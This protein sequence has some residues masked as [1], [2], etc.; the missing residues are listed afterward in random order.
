MKSIHQW[1]HALPALAALLLGIQAASAS[2]LHSQPTAYQ[3]RFAQLDAY[4]DGRLRDLS[5]P[6]AALVVVEGTD[7]VHEHAYGQ[8]SCA[9]DVPTPQTPF[10]IGS[11]TKSITA[12]AVMQLVEAG[13]IGLDDPVHDYLTWFRT[14]DPKASALITVRQLLNHTSGLSQQTGIRPLANFDDRRDAAERQARELASFQITRPPG[15]AF[16]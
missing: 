14:A 12:L 9:G 5:M 10:V 4:I 6:G 2:G 11:L 15:S 1:D 13:A 8:A 3:A 16:E 7:I